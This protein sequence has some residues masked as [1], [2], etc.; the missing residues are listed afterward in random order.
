MLAKNKGRGKIKRTGRDRGGRHADRKEQTER[1]AEAEGTERQAAKEQAEEEQAEEEQAEE[2]Q[3]ETDRQTDRQER[4][5]QRGG[6]RD[7]Q[8]MEVKEQV[9]MLWK[10][11]ILPVSEIICMGLFDFAELKMYDISMQITCMWDFET[12]HSEFSQLLLMYLL[13][14]NLPR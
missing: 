7:R 13:L 9:V 5:K 3:A 8:M 10:R 14:K 2:G 11:T 6:E 12:S 1:Q 4:N